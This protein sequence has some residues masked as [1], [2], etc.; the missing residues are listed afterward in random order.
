MF[1][2]VVPETVEI[3]SR[4][5]LYATL[6]LSIAVHILAL[7]GLALTTLWNI[8]FPTESPRL[9]RAYSLVAIPEPPPPPPPPLAPKRAEVAPPPPDEVA[10]PTVIPDTIPQ[11]PNPAPA[12]A[13]LAPGPAAVEAAT[14]PGVPGEIGR[15]HV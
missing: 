10:A 8:A 7:G 11:L 2:T 13:A 1:E 4:R 9:V 15:A 5:L 14:E 3:R 12:V 6:P